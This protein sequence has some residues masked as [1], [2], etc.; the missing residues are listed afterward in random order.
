M[1]LELINNDEVKKKRIIKYR[2]EQLIEK[3]QQWIK[4]NNR[5]PTEG[6]FYKNPKYPH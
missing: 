3:I 4:E 1:N 2:R 5:V 6:D